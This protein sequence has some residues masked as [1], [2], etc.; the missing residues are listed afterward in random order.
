MSTPIPSAA[1]ASRRANVVVQLREAFVALNGQVVPHLTQHGHQEVRAAHGAVFQYLDQ[2]G[3]TVSTLAERAQMTKQAM[4]ELVAHLERHDY[5]SRVPAPHDRR[6]KL[7][8][9]TDRGR[10]VVRL[11]RALVPDIEARVA[12]AI[13]QRRLTQLRADLERIRREFAPDG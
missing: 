6:A 4:A 13:G 7:V 5:V 10:E 2:E 3:T 11:A 9:L 8:L 12:R 1:G